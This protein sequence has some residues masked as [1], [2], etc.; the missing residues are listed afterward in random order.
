[1]ERLAEAGDV[2]GANLVYELMLRVPG[3]TSEGQQLWDELAALAFSDPEL[4]AWEEISLSA[5]AEGRLDRTDGGRPVRVA[6]SAEVGATED[7]LVASLER[8]PDRATPFALSG[9]IRAT[10]DGTT[11]TA[12]AAEPLAPGVARFVFKN[13]SGAPA[14]VSVVGVVGPHTW[15]ELATL[16]ADPAIVEEEPPDWVVEAGSIFDEAGEPGEQAA[17][18]LIAGGNT[19]GAVCVTGEWP[20]VEFVLSEPFEIAP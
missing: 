20:D 8:G 11:C 9:E 18:A 6:M 16:V 1:V 5:S 17:T 12:A 2:A 13:L 14:G 19:H 10:W 7:A 4:V 3:R 15:D